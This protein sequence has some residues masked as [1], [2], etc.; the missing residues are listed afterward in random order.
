MNIWPKLK[1]TSRIVCILLT[2]ASLYA[3]QIGERPVLVPW[4]K[5][6]VQ[7][8]TIKQTEMPWGYQYDYINGLGQSLRVEK[9]DSNR[10]LIS[11]VDYQYDADGRLAKEQ[12][13]DSEGALRETEDG[14]AIKTV[15]YSQNPDHSQIIETAYFKRDHTAGVSNNGYAVLR[16]TYG[17]DGRLNKTEFLDE[18]KKPAQATWLGVGNVVEIQYAYLM[19][20]SELIWAAFLDKSGKVLDRK[21]LSGSTEFSSSHTT[22]YAYPPPTTHHHHK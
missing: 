13:F 5:D 22:F 6:R 10:Q 1:H 9:R 18:Q 14:F 11:A 12:H 3:C 7:I 17:T 21:Q 20:A 19:G 4:M 2:M 15:R 16:E 8:G